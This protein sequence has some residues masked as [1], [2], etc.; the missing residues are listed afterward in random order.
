MTFDFS[1]NTSEIHRYTAEPWRVTLVDTGLATMTG[2][3][4]LHIKDYL[5]D[6]DFC[7]TYGDGLSNVD[8]SA[9]ISS[10]RR[11]G[12]LATVTAVRPPGR[13]GALQF[14][15]SGAKIDSFIEKPG[16]DGSWIN[17]GFFVLNPSVL[18]LIDDES[19]AWE[20]KP[21]SHLSTS[22]EL[23]AYRHSGFWQPM[24]TLRD[25]NTLESLW[26]SGAPPW[27]VWQ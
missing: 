14:D 26:D 6:D 11:S 25:K 10:H 13:F 19:T 22:G 1:L 16:G 27:A 7:L 9:L 4:L 8:I 17:G 3:R 18:G 15:S 24:D 5:D 21:L 23:N 12:C 20:D 2:G